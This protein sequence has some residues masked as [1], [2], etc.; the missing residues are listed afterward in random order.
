MSSTVDDL[1]DSDSDEFPPGFLTANLTEA[2]DSDED[3]DA[4]VQSG[5]VVE[6]EAPSAR[7]QPPVEFTPLLY[8]EK[9][10][11]GPQ[12]TWSSKCVYHAVVGA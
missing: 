11:V 9:K 2:R 8:R 3:F 7:P 12:H 10:C 4:P 6:V 1:S 5:T